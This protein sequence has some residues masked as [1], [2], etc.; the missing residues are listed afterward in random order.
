MDRQKEFTRRT[1]INSLLELLIQLLSWGETQ[2][3]SDIESFLE[4]LDVREC[5]PFAESYT[6]RIGLATLQ[7][8]EMSLW[9]TVVETGKIEKKFRD[10]LG[11]FKEFLNYA[12]PFLP[13]FAMD[14]ARMMLSSME[15]I[16]EQK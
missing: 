10:A 12:F 16:P 6:M 2:W 11:R 14:R 5:E 15:D 3:V 8:A 9:D 1:A 13:A 7:G 4:A